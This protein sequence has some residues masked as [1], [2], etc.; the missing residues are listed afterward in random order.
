MNQSTPSFL[1]CL[2]AA[3]VIQYANQEAF[4][5]HLKAYRMLSKPLF[6]SPDTNV[7]YHRFLTNSSTIDLREV[8]LVDTVREEIEASLNF[9][10]TPAQISEIKRGA[11]Y[12]QFLLDELVNRRM[13]KS[14][15][16][17]IALAEYRELRRYAVEIE[18]VERSTNDKEQ[19][20]LIIAK[21]LRRF[22][23]ERAALPVML[24][25]DRQMADLCEAEGIEHFHFTLPHAVQADFCSSRSMRRMIYNLAMVFG[26]IRLNSV[27]V[28]GEFKGK[29]RIDQLKLR[30]LDE[31]LWKGFEKHLR[32]CR[33]LMN[34]GIRQ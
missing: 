32:M 15:L 10:Y 4:D 25:A 24:T 13:K 30:F 20:D 21:T 23:K 6:L 22:E 5:E 34:L 27:V 1:Q 2:L 11:R 19:T 33:R 8:L 16:A 28:F 14:R 12:Q 9:K 26:V 17:C 7:L 3:G 29:K 31:E 18:G